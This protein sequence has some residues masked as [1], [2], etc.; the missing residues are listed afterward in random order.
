MQKMGFSTQEHR[1]MLQFIGDSTVDIV[2]NCLAQSPL[3]DVNVP[4]AVANL[5]GFMAWSTTVK[6]VTAFLKIN[7][8]AVRTDFAS[9]MSIGIRPDSTLPKQ[10]SSY[11]T[12]STSDKASKFEAEDEKFSK[13][14]GAAAD[15]KLIGMARE[16]T[17]EV[18]GYGPGSAL[19]TYEHNLVFS[20]F[21]GMQ[22]P[23]RQ[24]PIDIMQR[25]FFYNL[26]ATFEICCATMN[27]LR[28]GFMSL[29]GTAH[30]KALSHLL[31]GIR[32]AIEC[33][34]GIYAVIE[35]RRYLGFVLYYSEPFWVGIRGKQ[36]TSVTAAQAKIDLQ[37]ASAHTKSLSQLCKVLSEAVIKGTT[38]K[39][40]IKRDTVQ[41]ARGLYMEVQ[42][43]DLDKSQKDEIQ[44]WADYL[45]FPQEFL[46]VTPAN[47]AS[48]FTA[49]AGETYFGKDIPMFLG[50]GCIVSDSKAT[51]LCA[52]F[53]VTAPSLIMPKGE[54]CMISVPGSG[55]DASLVADKDGR[56]FMPFIAVYMKSIK[57]AAADLDSVFKNRKVSF[58]RGVKGGPSKAQYQFIGSNKDDIWVS[59]CSAV[60]TVRIAKSKEG[61][62]V[63][64]GKGKRGNTAEPEQG[65][66]K[67]T[68]VDE[69]FSAFL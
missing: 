4:Y 57:A 22:L 8:E 55:I 19:A 59:L 27:V 35:A 7:S 30:G 40:I 3:V 15:H 13:L 44:K 43:R 48:L 11:R 9:S 49:Y 54:D 58:R 45:S 67:K 36:V 34:V 56:A 14:S 12:T 17:S 69:D 28:K 26:G 18:S 16:H 65:P 62:K 47:L 51:A 32:L 37:L 38:D 52:A 39:E 61:D 42:R 23:D 31:Q 66:S 10:F 53:G 33:N 46:K 21:D 20:Y 6:M 29:S 64:K 41:T 68:R 50:G 24:A 2:K 63:K 1:N 25:F 5:R 60:D